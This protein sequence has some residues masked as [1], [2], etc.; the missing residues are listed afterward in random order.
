MS[1]NL[2]KRGDL[3][4]QVLDY[5]R[6]HIVPTVTGVLAL[7]DDAPTVPQEMTAREYG[8]T[9]MK[10]CA[11]HKGKCHKCELE[12]DWQCATPNERTIPIVEQWAKEHPERSEE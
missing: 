10:I 8:E 4:K 12:D 6:T 7:I 2:I 5:V 1:N 9:L 11:S 3:K